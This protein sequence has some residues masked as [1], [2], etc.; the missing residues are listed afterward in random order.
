MSYYVKQGVY[1]NVNGTSR[2]DE[3]LSLGPGFE[4]NAWLHGTNISKVLVDQD[5]T[6]KRFAL[7][8][9]CKVIP[10]E[11][12]ITKERSPMRIMVHMDISVFLADRKPRFIVN[13]LTRMHNTGFFNAWDTASKNEI[14]LEELGR[15]LHFVT[16]QDIDRKWA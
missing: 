3:L 5:Q 6:F 8:M 4:P 13:E 16:F 2:V 9:L 12:F 11:E 10:A 7:K 14:M 1:T 15:L